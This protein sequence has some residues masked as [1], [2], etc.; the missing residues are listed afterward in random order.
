MP[1]KKQSARPA[2]S[3]WLLEAGVI[4]IDKTLKLIKLTK[5]TIVELELFFRHISLKSTLGEAASYERKK[6]LPWLK[7]VQEPGQMEGEL[8]THPIEGQ[9]HYQRCIERLIKCLVLDEESKRKKGR[10]PTSDRQPLHRWLMDAG[11]LD[12]I[13]KGPEGVEVLSK[14]LKKIKAYCSVLSYAIQVICGERR[15]M[16]GNYPP[17]VKRW[18]SRR[19]L[20]KVGEIINLSLSI[21][22]QRNEALAL[23]ITKTEQRINEKKLELQSLRFQES[24]LRWIESLRKKV[25]D[26]CPS[27]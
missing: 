27:H 8:I 7:I 10:G 6:I 4:G 11:T 12:L 13:V 16:P 18:V 20:A 22:K 25:G 1:N 23:A 26:S 21:P 5:W 19:D 3:G 15:T 14:R 2:E 24:H 17:E 9:E